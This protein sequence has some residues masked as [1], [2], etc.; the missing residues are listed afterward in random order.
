CT[1]GTSSGTTAGAATT[2]LQQIQLASIA[3][4][5]SPSSGSTGQILI[6]ALRFIRK[7]WRGTKIGQ[8]VIDFWTLNLIFITMLAIIGSFVIFAIEAGRADLT[9]HYTDC[10]FL[11]ASAVTV[12]GMTPF[13]FAQF[14]QGSIV[15]CYCLMTLGST[16]VL[17]I[18]P[19]L[20]RR[21]LYRAR[22]GNPATQPK[23]SR[24]ES[25]RSTFRDTIQR[26]GMALASVASQVMP[27]VDV[28]KLLGSI[29]SLNEH[30][31][32][33]EGNSIQS[34]A[35][36]GTSLQIYPDLSRISH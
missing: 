8:G 10:L 23:R 24:L 21:Y 17:S 4:P 19:V 16:I 18:P 33:T 3:A 14:R 26:S 22:F 11:A 32:A 9:I 1:Q 2:P 20:I 29:T 34:T 27:K 30:G 7:V 12:T 5:N 36:Y 25:N 28:P 13:E 15:T 35:E 31:E 6:Q